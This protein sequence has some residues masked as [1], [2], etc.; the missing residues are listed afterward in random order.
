MTQEYSIVVMLQ[1]KDE[2]DE[3]FMNMASK[4]AGSKSATLLDVGKL[5]DSD[6]WQ[7]ITIVRTEHL[8]LLKEG[9]TPGWK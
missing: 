2:G 3:T 8:P 1:Q 6:D 9:T 4:D 5:M 7:A